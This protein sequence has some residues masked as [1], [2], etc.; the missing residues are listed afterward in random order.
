M[1][2]RQ[3]STPPRR[4][5]QKPIL[6]GGQMRWGHLTQLLAAVPVM[7]FYRQYRGRSAWGPGTYLQRGGPDRGRPGQ[8][9]TSTQEW[10]ET[11]EHAPER[12]RPARLT[13]QPLPFSAPPHPGPVGMTWF[14]QVREGL[15]QTDVTGAPTPTGSACL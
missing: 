9:Q 11:A 1:K 14:A 12:A 2:P 4:D 10:R 8:G 15:G 6:A 13:E 3:C 7:C 5:V